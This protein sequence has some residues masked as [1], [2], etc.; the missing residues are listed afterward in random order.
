MKDGNVVVSTKSV[1][2]NNH[3][4]V[5][6]PEMKLYYIRDK[7]FFTRTALETYCEKSSTPIIYANK[8]EYYRHFADQSDVVKINGN[9][10]TVLYDDTFAKYNFVQSMINGRPVWDS[11]Y[12]NLMMEYQLLKNVGV[13]LENDVYDRVSSKVLKK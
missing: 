9:Y 6:K 5:I 13:D 4:E 3:S 7:Y 11:I 8:M 1:L 10:Y 12:G 2:K